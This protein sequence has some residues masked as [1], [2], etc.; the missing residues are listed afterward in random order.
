M[1]KLNFLTKT[2][3]R[4][5]P[6]SFLHYAARQ[7]GVDDNKIDYAYKLFADAKRIDIQPLSGEGGRG[8]IVFLD[9]SLSLYF[10][11]DGDHFYYDGF[12]I[13]EYGK[14]EV[15]VFDRLG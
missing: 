9:C 6:I 8:F 12:E 7:Q 4:L 1:L 13:G 3:M 14:G 15:T 5:A 2:L 10:Y 11:Q